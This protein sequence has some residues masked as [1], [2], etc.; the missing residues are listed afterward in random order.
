[1]KLLLGY[2]SQY[3]ST[4]QYAE[5]LH[6][7]V[8]GELVSIE[9][10][11]QPNLAEFDILVFGGY[12]HAGKI[13]IR[14]VIRKHWPIIANK[15][16]VLFTTS[17]TPPTETALIQP[18]FEDSFPPEIREKLAY[19]PLWGRIDTARWNPADRLL[20]HIGSWI[21]KDPDVK[22]GM[23]TDF[24]G[25]RQEAL[26]PLVTHIQSLLAARETA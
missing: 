8:G 24:D 18:M 14:N 25:I 16:I 23:V 10:L 20:S 1:M 15:P 17:G 26:Q 4:Q 6:A 19:F 9:D 21:E 22:R 3:G 2:H 5:W 11:S 12:V 7:Q 13:S